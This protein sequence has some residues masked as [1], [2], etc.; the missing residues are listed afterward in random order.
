MKLRVRRFNS[1][2]CVRA[3][4][5]TKRH[6]QPGHPR[7]GR[8]DSRSGHVGY[9]PIAAD[10]SGAANFAMFQE[11][12]RLILSK[13]AV[14]YRVAL[15]LEL[16]AVTARRL[17]PRSRDRAFSCPQ[18]AKLVTGRWEAGGRAEKIF[19]ALKGRRPILA[20]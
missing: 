8:T 5:V 20:P 12:A 9:P 17:K 3:V 4:R 10:F 14:I 18:S 19:R 16:V 1:V 15:S 13:S 6:Q 11:Q 7:P 2:F